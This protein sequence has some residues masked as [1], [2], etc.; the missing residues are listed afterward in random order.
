VREPC[1]AGRNVL[2]PA[3]TNGPAINRVQIA[4]RIDDFASVFSL[5]HCT[6]SNA[7]VISCADRND[8]C[9]KLFGPFSLFNL[10]SEE[11]NSDTTLCSPHYLAMTQNLSIAR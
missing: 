1:A 2:N 7:Y 5:T 3:L 8:G 6:P 10:G 9:L 4:D 11:T